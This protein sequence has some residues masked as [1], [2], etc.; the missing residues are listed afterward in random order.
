MRSCLLA[1]LSVGILVAD[2]PAETHVV[3]PQGTGDFPTIQAAIDAAADGDVVELTNGVFLGDGNRDVSFLGKAL[4][5]RSRSG[6]PS[7]CII[8][9]DATP[10]D[11]HRGFVFESNETRSA[12]LEAVT[13]RNACH[14]WG[15]GI[16]FHLSSP[17]ITRCVFRHNESPGSEGG[18]LC[19]LGGASAL[20]EDCVFVDNSAQHG[21][22]ISDCNGLI[23]RTEIVGCTF[24]FNSAV[25]GGGVRY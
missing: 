19:I 20:I 1:C 3:N 8:D 22:A 16:S 2:V 6:D 14:Y 13:I 5:V 10:A 11:Q 7:V 18:G 15:G 4:T 9:C 23:D 21:G 17:T 12:V 24:L 25:L